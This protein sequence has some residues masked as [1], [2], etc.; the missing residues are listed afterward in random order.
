M[1]LILALVTLLLVYAYYIP[2]VIFSVIGFCLLIDVV[3]A[4]VVINSKRSVNVKLCW[5]FFISSF[6]LIGV[7]LFCV[8]GFQ[9]Y[10]MK[11]LNQY[12]IDWKEFNEKEDYSLTNEL[13]NDPKY[14]L[15]GVFKYNFHAICTP[16]YTK[17]EINLITNET[18]FYNECLT[19]IANAKQ[20][21]HLQTYIM[22]DGVFFRSLVNKLIPLANRG[23]E[24]SILYDW[25][26]S[27]G[28]INH[29]LIRLMQKSNIKVA[30]FNPKGINMYKGLTNYRSHQKCLIIDNHTVI[31]GG[32]NIG[33]E[34]IGI[35]DQYVYWRD[36]N[37]KIS[38][39]IVNSYNLNF[40]NNWM[41]LSNGITR[42]KDFVPS[43]GKIWN[44][45]KTT[46]LMQLV[47]SGPLCEEK[48]IEQSIINLIQNAKQSIKI[49]SPYFFPS[50]S[51]INALI[52]KGYSG[53]NIELIL[54]RFNN[55]KEFVTYINRKHY[56]KLL[57]AGIKIYE[58][59]GF[60][61]S[62]YIII[63]NQFVFS[64]S[65]NLDYRSL[66]INFENA[67]IIDDCNLATKLITVFNEDL[68]HSEVVLTK[69]LKTFNTYKFRIINRLVNFFHP[70]I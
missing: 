11:D 31:T 23:I 4:Y 5:V 35:S 52:T 43:Y 25:V 63:D 19:L 65:N 22:N 55:E 47:R 51:I 64:G 42:Y 53:L 68:K 12:Q 24:V 70:L 32:S 49:S 29:K 8:F 50:D 56:K 13:V 57:D 38:G 20:F 30:I 37:Y 7:F 16:I 45:V 54:P 26:G 59:Q 15:H 44:E 17:N 18:D 58:Y 62:K 34:Y 41:Q 61:H 33:D 46:S 10:V 9:P 39:E 6:P 69:D 66:W 14:E 40:I 3:A 27:Y 36:L 67:L 28:R 1:S 2:W 48:A 21:I 60:I